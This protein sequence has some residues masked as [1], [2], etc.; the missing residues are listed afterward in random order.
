M[1]R[2]VRIALILLVPLVLL[3]VIGVAF[4]SSGQNTAY[5]PQNEFRLDDWVKIKLGS[6]DL[7]INKAVL[8]LFLAAAL[9]ITI[10]VWI[11]NRMQAKPNR[12][13]TAIEATYDLSR[14]NITFGNMDRD[15]ALKWFPF[16]AAVFFF[17]GFSPPGFLRLLWRRPE[18]EDR[19][20]GDDQRDVHVARDAKPARHFRCA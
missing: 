17:I 3:I 18:Q 16:C 8:Y 15:Y 19:Q 2:R 14:N 12:I 11:A 10:M 5:Q 4:G 13:Q 7:S 1:S 20:R 9:T 6:L